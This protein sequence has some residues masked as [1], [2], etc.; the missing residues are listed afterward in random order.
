MAQETEWEHVAMSV[1]GAEG[2]KWL[3]ITAGCEVY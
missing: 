1:K 2:K 3:L